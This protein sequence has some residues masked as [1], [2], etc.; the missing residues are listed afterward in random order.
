MTNLV[1]NDVLRMRLYRKMIC[2]KIFQQCQHYNHKIEMFN[3]QK[4]FDLRLQ[5]VLDHWSELR[6]CRETTSEARRISGGGWQGD[7]E[8]QWVMVSMWR[9][10]HGQTPSST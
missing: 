3:S 4:Q 2:F 8:E 6:S 9:G 5:F 7:M 1:R 10:R